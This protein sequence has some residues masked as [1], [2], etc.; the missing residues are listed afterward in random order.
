M[1]NTYQ[2]LT[3]VAEFMGWEYK[4]KGLHGLMFLTKEYSSI[5]ALSFDTM[6]MVLDKFKTL[7]ID[8]SNAD[9]YTKHKK[10]IF[11]TIQTLGWGTPSDCAARLADAIEWWKSVE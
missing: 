2:H 6:R 1:T 7:D 9:N 4:Q 5:H 3:T 10:L 8:P 11:D